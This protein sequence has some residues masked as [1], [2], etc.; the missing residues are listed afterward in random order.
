MEL[1][2][3][4]TLAAMSA[5]RFTPGTLNEQAVETVWTPIQFVWGLGDSPDGPSSRPIL[6]PDS[7]A[8]ASKLVL[9]ERPLDVGSV[10]LR[11]LTSAEGAAFGIKVEQSSGDA[12]LDKAAVRKVGR[13][14]FIPSFNKGK[15]QSGNAYARYEMNTD[16]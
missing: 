9:F 10:L 7:C 3:D 1:L 15:P 13:C 5:C 12:M 14:K 16:P 11:F 6:L 8:G 4:A 2:D